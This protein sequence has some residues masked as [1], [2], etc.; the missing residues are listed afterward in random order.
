[1][2]TVAQG[3]EH[4]QGKEDKQAYLGQLPAELGFG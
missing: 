1:M 4:V 2:G 3:P